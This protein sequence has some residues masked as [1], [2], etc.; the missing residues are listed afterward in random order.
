[1]AITATKLISVGVLFFFMLLT[2]FWVS[3]SEK[4]Y[5]VLRPTLHHVTPYLTTI[6]TG[7]SL[8]LLHTP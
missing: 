3:R 1:M 2:G 8:A 4:P 5:G 6:A 7:V